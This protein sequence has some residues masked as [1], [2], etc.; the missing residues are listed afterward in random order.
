MGLT[1]ARYTSFDMKTSLMHLNVETVG[2]ANVI[3]GS[4]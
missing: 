3:G 4:D 2:G 1:N